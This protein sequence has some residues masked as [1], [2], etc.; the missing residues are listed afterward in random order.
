VTPLLLFFLRFQL[1]SLYPAICE[2]SQPLPFYLTAAFFEG[3]YL[4]LFPVVERDLLRDR[5]FFHV[6]FPYDLS[7]KLPP[8]LAG[9]FYNGIS[10]LSPMSRFWPLCHATFPFISPTHRRIVSWF[11][12]SR[13][14]GNVP[15]FSFYHCPCWTPR[16]RPLS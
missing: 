9:Y 6:R 2:G 15:P 7:F 12:L 5:P 3:T 8:H 10:P 4:F 14:F 13:I 11:F 16:L 1:P